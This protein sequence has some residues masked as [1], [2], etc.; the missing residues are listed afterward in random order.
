[1]YRSFHGY[2]VKEKIGAGGMS[3]VYRG[4]H[5]TLGY[6]V[7]IKILHPGLAGDKSFIARFEREAKAASALRSN[8]I[9]SV[10]DFGSEDDVYFIVMEF[11]DGKDLGQLFE[12]L[13]DPGR[14][15]RGFPVEVAL[16][17]LE[18]VG[19]GLKEAHDLGIIHRDIKPSNILLNRRGEVKIADFGLARDTRDM[20]RISSQD[21]TRPGTVVGTPSYMSPEQAAGRDNLDARTDIFS[22][23]VMA[24]QLLTGE[25]PFKGETPTE[26]QERIINEAP[27]PLSSERCPLLTPQ[28][29]MLIDKML[30]KDPAKRY[31][32]L[33]QVLRALKE[34]LESIDGAGGAAKYRRD[35]LQSFATDPRR[36]ADELRHR[37]IT[38]HLKRGYHFKNMGLENIGDAMR[39]FRR[40]LMVDPENPKAAEA[41]R[42]LERRLEESGAH[43]SAAQPSAAT[44]RT[45]ETMV[46]P[47]A[48]ETPA[49]G[50]AAKA[51]PP[52]AP[53]P[54]EGPRGPRATGAAGA[55]GAAGGRRVWLA[56]GIGVAAVAIILAVVLG[57]PRG[58]EPAEVP[59]PPAAE[60]AREGWL[61][62]ATEPAGA[63]LRLRPQGSED[64]FTTLPGSS[65]LVTAGLAPGAWEVQAELPGHLPETWQV[66][67]AA[68]DTARQ[69]VALRVDPALGRI[70]V[71]STPSGA[72]VLLR[73]RGG[74]FQPAGATPWVSAPLAPGPWEVRLELEGHDART[75]AVQ[76][77]AGQVKRLPL[78]L[79]ATAT[80]GAT[81]GAT[82]GA[83]GAT[84]SAGAGRPAADAPVRGEGSIKVV[85]SPYADIY[86][87][88]KRVKEETNVA[89]I[90]AAAGRRVIELRHPRTYASIRREVTVQAGQT[91]TLPPLTFPLGS[92]R[93]AAN[94]AAHVSIDGEQADRQTPLALA[95][96]GAGEHVISVWLPGYT[97]RG[98]WDVSGGGERELR[99]RR[100]GE[101]PPRFTVTVSEGQETR[102]RFQLEK[103]D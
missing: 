95:K 88:G 54:R 40:V 33:E 53:A 13:Q 18:E 63:T 12:E 70:D 44:D 8:N 83:A 23:G 87:D 9:A 82:A 64:A 99:P 76:V 48:A 39:E 46:M 103:A 51:P 61:A 27:P 81:A 36:C 66:A 69:A 21:L 5:A 56:G 94:V 2:E 37:N 38:D 34:C 60:A 100:A 20:A 73:Q 32:S 96:V 41:I 17:L 14:K 67:V 58:P 59:P 22:L 30:A 57:R 91:V 25:K 52:R 72:R 29:E 102:L 35:Y 11:I 43:A 10:I 101:S 3:T 62:L 47:A 50:A 65:P 86:L 77:A 89:V 24:Y 1:M 92:L 16:I 68:G 6:P 19:Y 55:A 7:A 85:V 80:G 75:A 49:K 74:E 28:I 71:S 15:P 42:E 84:G 93:M 26:V 79:A 45:G 97:V 31:Q 90:T 4:L 78:T 98:A